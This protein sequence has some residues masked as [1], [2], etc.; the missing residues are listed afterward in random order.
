VINPETLVTAEVPAAP[1]NTPTTT[2]PVLKGALVSTYDLLEAS[3]LRVG[4]ARL[5]IF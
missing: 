1:Y 4:V 5:V 3:V 2:T